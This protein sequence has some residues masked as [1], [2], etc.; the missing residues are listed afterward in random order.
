MQTTMDG[1]LAMLQRA[2]EEF[3]RERDPV[4][5]TVY[6][7][8]SL[9][10]FFIIFNPRQYYSDLVTHYTHI[11]AKSY[12]LLAKEDWK[13]CTASEFFHWLQNQCRLSQWDEDHNEISLRFF[14][15]DS[16]VVCSSLI[17]VFSDSKAIFTGLH[18][19]SLVVM[20]A[21]I[22]TLSH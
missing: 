21:V 14:Y 18:Y 7:R 15:E 6:V 2:H 20:I 9:W 11:K 1:L 17:R 22:I 16:K 12:A 4:R 13:D 8:F 5:L 3:F 10:G 19:S